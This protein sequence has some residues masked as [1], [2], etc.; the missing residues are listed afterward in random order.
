MGNKRRSIGIRVIFWANKPNL[1]AVPQSLCPKHYLKQHSFS[2]WLMRVFLV[3]TLFLLLPWGQLGAAPQGRSTD[4]LPR[5]LG[6]VTYDPGTGSPSPRAGVTVNLYGI[7]AGG[8]PPELQDS[9]VSGPD[10]AYVLSAAS[11]AYESFAIVKDEP[12]GLVP[13]GA[14]AGTGGTVSD[15]SMVRYPGSAG[16]DICCSDFQLLYPF[17]FFPILRDRYLIVTTAAIVPALD[18]FITYKEFLGFDMEVITIE[19]LDPGG[20]GGNYLRNQIRDYEKSLLNGPGGLDYVL[21]IGTDDT[22][23]F[24]KLEPAK[25]DWSRTPYAEWPQVCK[26]AGLPDEPNSCGWPTDWFYVDLTS[27]W[28]SNNDGILGEAFW[29][30][31]YTRDAP[32]AFNVDVFLGRLPFD[33]AYTVQQVLD[34]I[35]AFEQD[36][37]SWKLNTL[38]TGAMMDYG[39]EGWEPKDNPSGS[40]VPYKGPTDSGQL[41]EKVWSNILQSEGF[42]RIRLYEKACPPTGSPPSYLPV[43]APLTHAELINR[44]QAQDYGLVKAAGHGDHSGVYRVVWANDYVKLGSVQNP[45]EPLPPDDKSEH[46]LENRVFLASSDSSLLETPSQKAPILMVMACDTGSWLYTPNLPSVLLSTGRISAWTGGT[47][48]VRYLAEWTLP[49]DGGAHTIDYNITRALFSDGRDL[50]DAVWSGLAT[51]H[52][53]HGSGWGDGKWDWGFVGWDLYGD[54]SMNYWGNGPDLRSPWPMFHYDWPGRGETA[55]SGPGPLAEVYWNASIGPTAPGSRTPSPVIGRDGRIVIG[56]GSGDVHVFNASGTDLW[57]YATGE[58]IDNA[59]ALSVDGTAYVQTTG[60]T[61]YAIQADGTLRWSRTVGQSDAS[62]KIAGSGAIYV[63]GSDNNGPGGSTR[64]L[65]LVYSASGTRAASAV[66][67]DRVTTAPSIGPD[68]T[69]WV[70]TAAG[71]LYELSSDLSTVISHSI[72]PGLAIGDGLALADD[73]AETVLV[74]TAAGQVVAW[75]AVS[76]TVSW[77]FTTSDTVRSAPAVGQEGK[78]FIGSQDGKVYALQLSD[79]SKLW[80]Y[81]TGGPVDSSPAVDAVHVYVVGGDPVRLHILRG[82][83]G[84][85]YPSLVYIGGN[86]LGGS[87]PAIG[88]SKKVYVASSAGNLV[89]VGRWQMPPPP[90]L[91]AR[92]W[93]W[94]IYV[95]L[96]LG[97]PLALHVIERRLPGGEWSV[98]ATLNP[99]VSEF[100][101]DRVTAGIV[102]QYRAAAMVS[103]KEDGPI[104]NLTATRQV[105]MSEYSP[106]VQVQALRGIPAAPDAPT[107]TARSS[108]EL[109]LSWTV[110]IS[111]PVALRIWRQDPGQPDFQEIALIPG[112]TTAFVDH[113]LISDSLYAYQLQAVDEAHESALG[114]TG[115]GQTWARTLPAPSQVTVEALPQT[116]F[117]VCWVPGANDLDSVVARRPDGAAQPEVLGPVLAGQNCFTDTNA[118]PYTFEYWVKHVQ[119]QDESD[120][121]W[122]GRV[123]AP[124]ATTSHHIF[125]PLILTQG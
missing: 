87:S 106:I 13:G 52:L 89:A 69:V 98:M 14:T 99:G 117:R 80:E 51:Y 73:A 58:P 23:P 43:D 7:P 10:G 36:G 25:D 109:H 83:D 34:T 57:S 11:S 76:D 107:V 77:T 64:Y 20:I 6:T 86:A 68:G 74:P 85:F 81:D 9:A 24:L 30:K 3:A 116:T 22:V 31:G 28:D 88:E 100:H 114:P 91:V 66:V 118:Y 75:S 44:W 124:G 47:G 17:P 115:Q 2:R 26:A 72:S 45:T 21:L 108:S 5:F 119:D 27:N 46:E 60:G 67:D 111:A 59:A 120:W 112:G 61:L 70:G 92:E 33:N 29:A 71:T 101:D 1:T 122:S 48:T 79:G 49:W 104:P 113:D 94:E 110:P 32:P 50:G 123:S 19:E 84:A 63:G 121:A 37:G 78:V 41:M 4:Q 95:Q 18:D 65:L 39:E 38:L 35:M 40:Y 82:S 16:G 97:D 103:P 102:Y 62:P 12:R 54:P 53:T 96:E 8:G 105:T 55:L 125:L 42:T 56:D 93:P 90:Y 15:P